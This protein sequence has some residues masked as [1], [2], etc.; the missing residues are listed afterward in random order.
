MKNIIKKIRLLIF[1]I[2]IWYKQPRYCDYPEA[3]TPLFGC[4]G[5]LYNKDFPKC[6]KDCELNKDLK[7]DEYES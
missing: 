2:K 7:K 4:W 1:K 6:C 3:A 5:L